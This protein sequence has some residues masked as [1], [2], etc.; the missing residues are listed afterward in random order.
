MPHHHDRA[1]GRH[2]VDRLPLGHMISGRLKY[3]VWSIGDQGA[4]ALHHIAVAAIDHLRPKPRRHVQSNRVDVDRK[5]ARD[6]QPAQGKYRTLADRARPHDTDSA[7]LVQRHTRALD[8]MDG[9]A[10][11]IEEHI[12]VVE[13]H[14]GIDGQYAALRHSHIL[15]VGA[16]M[17]EANHA[18]FT[19]AGTGFT[20][21]A[22]ATGT[23]VGDEVDGASGADFESSASTLCH[24]GP[25]SFVPWGNGRT[26]LPGMA[27]AA[28]GRARMD[29]E[30]N[31]SRTGCRYGPSFQCD[32]SLTKKPRGTHRLGQCCTHYDTF[33]A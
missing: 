29:A 12:R 28:A 19:Q 18:F 3:E 6:T 14:V 32:S 21:P 17:R 13:V 10:K 11:H 26:M 15:G 16:I 20:A 31:F 7:V 30:K 25:R 4:H 5:N 33:L 9:S 1:A 24:H 22:H 27:V 2:H 8:C 23:T